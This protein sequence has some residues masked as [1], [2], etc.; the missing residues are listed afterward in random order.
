MTAP[1]SPT[2]LIG[3]ALDRLM[4]PEEPPEETNRLRNAIARATHRS[5][6]AARS[7]PGGGG[8]YAGSLPASRP[9]FALVR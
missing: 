6:P 3:T 1:T 4:K 5:E 2:R 7:R 8:G 9:H